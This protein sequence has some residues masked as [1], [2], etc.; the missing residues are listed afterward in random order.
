MKSLL[1]DHLRNEALLKLGIPEIFLN[2]IGKI[3]DIAFR[4][5]DIENAKFYLPTISNY[6]IFNNCDVI[7]VFDE[8]TTFCVILKNENEQKIVKFYL[9]DDHIYRDYGM[10]WNLLL[11]DILFQYYEDKV[12]DEDPALRN[13]VK[14]GEQVG[15]QKS[16]E[17]FRL[18]DLPINEYNEKYKNINAWK[19]EIA[20]SLNII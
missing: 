11:F 4:V 10:N 14:V 2:N 9:E 17:L 18:I 6:K 16:E 15:F 20:Q 7:P 13:F 12:V 5:E 8:G 3:Q 19:I 1:L